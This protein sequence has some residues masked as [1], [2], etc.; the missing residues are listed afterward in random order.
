MSNMFTGIIERTARVVLAEDRPGS[1]L[2]RIA[3]G[4]GGLDARPIEIGESIALNGACLTVVRS[5][6]GGGQLDLDFETVPETLGLTTLGTL[7]VGDEVNLERSLAAGDLLGGHFVSGHVDGI[8]TVRARR[9]EGDQVLFEI[10]VPGDLLRQVIR[11]GSVAVDG[12]SLTVVGVDR[13]EGWFSFAAIP[14][15]LERT[16][17]KA[18][19]VGSRVNL[20]TDVFGKW[21]L[22]AVGEMAF[23][24]IRRLLRSEDAE[25]A[26]RVPC[27]D[28]GAAD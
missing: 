4:S 14:H 18:R 27:A 7:A 1:R 17:L 5:R 3:T 26:K 6:S 12:V 15:T 21:V 20:E 22:H 9:P 13:R 8:G 24:E 10:D 2:I 11:K 23:E 19:T 16:C 25:P 28:S